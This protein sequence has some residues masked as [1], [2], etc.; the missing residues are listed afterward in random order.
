MDTIAKQLKLKGIELNR[1][2]Q[3]C[4]EALEGPILMLASP[5]SGKTTTLNARIAHMILNKGINPSRLL[6]ITYSK[7]GAIEMKERFQKLFPQL[8]D[9]RLAISTIHSLCY[10]ITMQKLNESGMPY[11][12]IE[13]S[14]ANHLHKKQ[15]L[16][17][18][19]EARHGESITQEQLE[20][21][22]TFIS[23]VKN[24][25]LSRKEYLKISIEV[26]DA[27][28]LL[29]Q[30]EGLKEGH[31]HGRLID[32]DD[33]LT[34][35]YQYL[36]DDPVLLKR[37]Q[38]LYDYVLV[39]EAQDTSLL[40]HRIIEL[41][42]SEHRNVCMVADDDQTIYSWRGADPEYLLNFKDVYPDAR[43]LLMQQNF[44][45]GKQL[46]EMTNRFIKGNKQRYEKEMRTENEFPSEYQY[47]EFDM[48]SLQYNYLVQALSS[49]DHRNDTAV[50][51][52]NNRSSIQLMDKLD[53]AG[54]PFRMKEVDHAFFRNFVLEDIRNIM[55]LSYAPHR[56][57]VFKKVFSKLGLFLQKQKVMSIAGENSKI[58]VFQKLMQLTDM[59]SKQMDQISSTE[60]IIRSLKSEKPTTALRLIKKEL[61]YEKTL[62]KMC[63]DLKMKEGPLLGIL[64]ELE[65]IAD[66]CE[67]LPDFVNRLTYLENLSKNSFNQ[68]DESAVFLSTFH[69][70]KG[71]EFEKVFIIETMDGITPSSEAVEDRVDPLLLEEERRLFY[72][73]MTRAKAKL[74]LMSYKS[75]EMDPSRFLVEV[76]VLKKSDPPKKVEIRSSKPSAPIPSLHLFQKGEG[77]FH[78]KFGVGVISSRED[79]LVKVKFQTHGTK[80][81]LLPNAVA[82]GAMTHMSLVE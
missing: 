36:E 56:F 12:M 20:A 57:D 5:G 74:T 77:V 42:V 14:G 30:Y 49:A 76:G 68:D 10:R 6:A 70:C 8:A 61:N 41:L 58:S 44:R 16:R 31:S 27:A 11:V 29:E 63:K 39:D 51:Y 66:R 73:A 65:E 59:S 55:R 46:V 9:A 47:K 45:S 62:K 38:S 40:Q 24:Q 22:E 69:S 1:E 18:L 26:P 33:M 54:I 13:A 67:T 4:V 71:L 35:A 25:L 28:E 50:L 15:I 48:K 52:R 75:K 7:A 53:R 19:F 81:L 64:S 32:Y 72:V 17:E 3:E 43:V 37:M 34:L 80:N 60:K 21:L 79:E 23:R 78:K 82:V 2:Q